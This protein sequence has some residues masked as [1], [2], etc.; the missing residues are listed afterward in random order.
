M[1]PPVTAYCFLATQLNAA[2][3]QGHHLDI[4]ETRAH[5]HDHTLLNWIADAIPD[6]NHR[7]DVS[8]FLEDAEMQSAVHEQLEGLDAGYGPTKFGVQNNGLGLVLAYCVEGA[9]QGGRTGQWP[10]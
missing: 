8:P 2:I 3:D 1:L 5:I 9:Q 7:I 4:D 6:P 10:G